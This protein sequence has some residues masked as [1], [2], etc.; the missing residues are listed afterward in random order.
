MRIEF[1]Q[2]VHNARLE[3]G[4][5]QEQI[6]ELLDTCCINIRKIEQGINSPNMQLYFSL[7]VLLNIETYGLRK[8]YVAPYLQ[9]RVKESGIDIMLESYDE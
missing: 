6:A 3:Q 2:M 8:K 5:T 9:K 4:L 7:C 1:G